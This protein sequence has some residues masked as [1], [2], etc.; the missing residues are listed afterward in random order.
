M[1]SEQSADD[2]EAMG[3]L[4]DELE[5]LRSMYG[6][7]ELTVARSTLP[8]GG[9][10]DVVARLLPRL[11]RSD[12]VAL[13]R[14]DVL[15][16]ARAP[17]YPARA[18]LAATVRRSDG[19]DDAAVAALAAALAAAVAEAA[20]AG[21]P[22]ML[23]A[24]AAAADALTALNA[25]A[26]AEAECC[27]CLDALQPPP[28]AAPS[29][30]LPLRRRTLVVLPACFHRFHARCLAE[31]WLVAW[32]AAREA[33]V[34]ALLQRQ[35]YSLRARQTCARAVAAAGTLAWMKA[36]RRDRFS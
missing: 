31:H 17:P 7:D 26:A 20:A 16:R 23:A 3:S 29:S 4:D 6:D 9:A 21:E 11:A 30:A 19:L 25:M 12:D 14:A 34:R 33:E 24:L 35:H 32:R 8:G 10:A 36:A 2:S 1:A 27:I 28:G 15:L 13:V 18:P 22:A 5:C